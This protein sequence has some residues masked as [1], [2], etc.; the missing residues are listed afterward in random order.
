MI[1]VIHSAIVI[2][3]QI[4]KYSSLFFTDNI[5]TF[6]DCFHTIYGIKKFYF[7]HF[8]AF[9]FILK[10][11]ICHQ[12]FNTFLCQFADFIVCHVFS[13]LFPFFRICNRGLRFL[14]RSLLFQFLIS[15]HLL[16]LRLH[17]SLVS[18]TSHPLV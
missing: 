10:F 11:L 6:K 5:M 7:N 4:Q 18:S 9:S 14:C 15:Y 3:R 17:S 16:Y 12:C 8:L 2:I 13:V 1:V